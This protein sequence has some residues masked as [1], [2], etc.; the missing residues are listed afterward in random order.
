M[1][2]NYELSSKLLVVPLSW[3]SLLML[4]NF[5]QLIIHTY[6]SSNW[7]ALV[8]ETGSSVAL[9]GLEF[10]TPA[11]ASQMLELQVFIMWC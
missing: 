10:M 7:E 2:F 5:F 11:F 4:F 8:F 9:A 1:C 3:E 6:N